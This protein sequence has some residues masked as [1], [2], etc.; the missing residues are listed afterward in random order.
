VE[1]LKFALKSPAPYIASLGPKKRFE[2][3]QTAFAERGEP[4]DQNDL[5]RIHAPCGLE[6]GADSPEEIALS[7]C[8]EIISSFTGKEG[9]MLRYKLDPIHERF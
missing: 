6:I 9:G 7:I 3:I 5:T 4:I 2:K 1:N 8:S